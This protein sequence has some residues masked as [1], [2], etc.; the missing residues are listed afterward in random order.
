MRPVYT[1]KGKLWLYPGKAGWYFFT[2]NKKTGAE[3]KKTQKVRRGWGSIP[4][5]A[6]IGKTT[7][8]T[9]IFPD[10]DGTYLLPIKKE[11]RKKERLESDQLITVNIR[12]Q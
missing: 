8:Q 6:T 11:I 5:H 7:W 12:K 2:V 4:V 10:K 3:M 9:S 1:L